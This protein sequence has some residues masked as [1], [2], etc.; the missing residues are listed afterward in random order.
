MAVLITGGAGYIGAHV[1]AELTAHGES[2][3]I[4]D[5]LSTGDEQRIGETPLV[6]LD[7]AG[8][9]AVPA[10]RR[11]LVDHDVEAVIHLAAKKQVPES[12]QRPLHYYAQNVGGL[13]NVLAAVELEGVTHLVLSSSA[14]VYGD[15]RTPS[16]AETATTA[17][18][19]PYGRTKLTGEWM[20]ADAAEAGVVS[21][22][23]LRY[24][25]VAGAAEPRLADTGAGNLI[26]ITILRMLAGHRPVIFGTDY[27]TADG[28]C[29]RDFVH[30]VDLARAHVAA[31]RGLRAGTA[32]PV[33]NVGTGTGT[34][35]RQ[36]VDAIRA[37]L[38][39]DL[40]PELLPRRA[41][42][43]P[44]VVADVR[45]IHDGLGWTADHTVEQ[46][47]ASAVEGLQR[48]SA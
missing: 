12:V 21:A 34:S 33:Y 44:S 11:V 45:R 6:R 48:R 4:V 25:N 14:A 43:P 27:D 29:V 47:V 1:L 2:A 38:G 42:D 20:V 32:E 18:V 22:C 30:V 31:L 37:R 26:P 28:T 5:D 23:S 9:D 7:L 15:V 35:V 39:A 41:G 36:I 17:P 8:N 46:M 24:F 13:A 40:A 3:V 10:L 16:V 19:N